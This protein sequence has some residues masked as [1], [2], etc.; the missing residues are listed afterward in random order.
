MSSAESIDAL[1]RFTLETAVAGGRETLVW[2]RRNVDVENKASG[3]DF[4]S[5]TGADELAR[6]SS[7]SA[8]KPNS[9]TMLYKAKNSAMSAQANGPGSLTRSMARVRL[10]VVFFTGECCWVYCAMG[11]RTS[12]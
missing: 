5:V 10:S 8:F 1:K 9:R 11:N 3:T 7:V 12:G 6:R 2:F 4:D